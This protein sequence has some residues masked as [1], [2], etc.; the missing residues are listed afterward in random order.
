MY[1]RSDSAVFTDDDRA[2]QRD[3]P[4]RLRP[5]PDC[6][7]AGVLSLPRDLALDLRFKTR[8]DKLVRFEQ[9]FWPPRV[10]PP[11]FSSLDLY[12]SPLT[13]HYP[14]GVGH[15]ELPP[16][17]GL[18]LFHGVKDRGTKNVD[19]DQGQIRLGFCGLLDEIYWFPVLHL[20]DPERGGV[21]HRR[22]P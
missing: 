16:R 19:A 14:D 17:A 10:F 9:V 20:D 21:L 15:L 7:R 2:P 8:E 1:V 6:D 13:K 12:P 22:D 11:P 5:P 3:R 4:N 18:D